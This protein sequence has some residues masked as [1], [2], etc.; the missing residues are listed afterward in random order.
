MGWRA[1]YG[2]GST[3]DSQQQ[4]PDD[5]ADG[6]AGIVEFLEPP[7][8]KIIDGGDWFWYDG[9]RWHAS[10][11]VW[12]GWVERPSRNAVRGAGLDDEDWETIRQRMLSDT[13][14]V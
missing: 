7:Y 14:W 3:V 1:Y 13:N 10:D 5:L 6:V 9:D 8:R 11:T 2:D 12:G 4:E